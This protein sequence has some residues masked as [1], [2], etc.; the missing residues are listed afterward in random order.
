MIRRKYGNFLRH[1][2]LA[3]YSAIILIPILLLLLTSFKHF[4]DIITGTFPFTPTLTNYFTLFSGSK[5]NF[6]SATRNS[7]IT[8]AGTTLIVL[9][10]A[11][12]GAYSLSRFQWPGWF[13]NLIMGGLLVI[14]LLPPIVF[15]GPFYLISIQLGIYNTP[16]AI[17]MAHSAFS[18]PLAVTVLYDFFANVPKEIEEAAYIDG[19]NKFQ[20]FFQVISP[21]ARPGIATAGALVFLFS[22][23]EFM[24]AL[25]L[26][27]TTKGMTIP[28]GVA[29]F[30]EEY[31]ILY[32]EMTASAV[33]SM[34]P[35]FLIVI[36]AGKN[37]ISG[38]TMG[39]VKG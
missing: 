3:S 20:T 27:T 33:I 14:Y 31:N 23:K 17:I 37:I 15:I 24:L 18:F 38:I 12:L 10:I 6:L 1:F 7:I 36:L 5:F 19:A 2:I 26:T 35:A 30:V 32:G 39:A 34:I 16:L 13:R 29:S 8:S 22:W 9:F 28:V 21:I 11:S 4:R 25:T